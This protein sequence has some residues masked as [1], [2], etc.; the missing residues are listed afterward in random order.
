MDLLFPARGFH[1][2]LG[3]EKQPA[4]TT[5]WIQNMRVIDC[6]DNRFRGGQRPG[7]QKMYDQQIGGTSVP[8][9]WIGFITT[10]D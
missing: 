2:G 7:L 9:V 8:I 1:K 5:P 10:V 6:Q 4:G 3:A